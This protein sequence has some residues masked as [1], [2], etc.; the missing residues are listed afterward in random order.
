L[1]ETA[2]VE[3]PVKRIR[4]FLGINQ[5]DFGRLI[6]RSHQ[7]VRNYENGIGEIPVEVIKKLTAIAAEKGLADVALALNREEDWHGG[8]EQSAGLS[9][10]KEKS[11]IAGTPDELH[12]ALARLMD[13]LDKRAIVALATFFHDIANVQSAT[14]A[15]GAKRSNKKGRHETA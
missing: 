4:T 11:G 5:A 3:S 12:D 1:K 10:A 6:G 13:K 7:S 15:A 9:F 14:P 8:E 2:E